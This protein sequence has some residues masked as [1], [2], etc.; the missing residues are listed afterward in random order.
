MPGTI[1]LHRQ[2][3]PPGDPETDVQVDGEGNLTIPAALAARLGLYP[4]NGVIL[5]ASARGVYTV[6]QIEESPLSA[7]WQEPEYRAFRRWLCAFDLPP[8]FGCGGCPSTESNRE[9]CTGDPFPV[10][11][12]CLWAQGI[13]LCP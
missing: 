2:Q 13:V 12:E 1:G 6:G 5:A 3:L 10:C 9:D 4:H 11:S 7:I 8:C